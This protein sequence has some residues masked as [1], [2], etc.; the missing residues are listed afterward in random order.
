MK[1]SRL[2][3][4]AAVAAAACGLVSCESPGKIDVKYPTVQQMDALD[5]QWGLPKRKPR[6]TPSRSM[7]YDAGGVAPSSAAPASSVP[8][9]PALPDPAL[10]IVPAPAPAIPE[11]LR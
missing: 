2:F 5:M 11:Q 4:S 6:G 8:P 10:D 9:S 7:S 3:V 1:F